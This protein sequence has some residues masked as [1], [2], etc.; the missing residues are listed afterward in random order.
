MENRIALVAL[1]GLPKIRPGDDLPALIARHAAEAG[2]E[3]R[4]DDVLVVTQKVVSKAEGMQVP[5]EGVQPS[6]RALE[7]AEVTGKDPRLLEV[8]LWD[9]AEVLRAV[10]GIIVVEHR[11]GF[12]CANAGV[13]MSN[14]EGGGAALRLPRDPDA[15]ARRL[16]E[17]L[18]ALLGVS[19][20]V[21][22]C[23]SHG[24]AW[25]EGTV[26]VAIGFSGMVGLQ[27]LRG[28]P[29][30]FGYRLQF[31]KVGLA[32]QVAAAAT[33]LMGQ[34]DEGLPVVVVR[35]LRFLPDESAGISS[36]LR[37][38]ERDLFR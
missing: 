5:L 36:L 33:L 30:L 16:R 3:I 37:A 13:D 28:M 14:V 23:D 6:P 35:G 25:R 10:R 1:P 15:S 8:M 24:R 12:V 17:G 29:D 31:T 19:P 7:L 2:I 11:L 21:I 22:I 38:R 18:C 9:T 32:D 34:A 4:G 26:G 27:D 20:P